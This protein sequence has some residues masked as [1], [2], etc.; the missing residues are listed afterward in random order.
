MNVKQIVLWILALIVLACLAAQFTSQD[1]D[2]LEAAASQLEIASLETESSSSH[3]WL[4]GPTI[5]LAASLAAILV[6][7][8]IQFRKSK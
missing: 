7:L 5:A 8:A 3:T 6:V 2:G 1:P 4:R